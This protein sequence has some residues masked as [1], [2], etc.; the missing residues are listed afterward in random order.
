MLKSYDDL[1]DWKR[2]QQCISPPSKKTPDFI[3][4]NFNKKKN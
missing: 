2:Q 3:H 4:K 1:K